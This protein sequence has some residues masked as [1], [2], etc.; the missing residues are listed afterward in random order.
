MTIELREDEVIAAIEN[1]L[2]LRFGF[3]PKVSH[4]RMDNR[5][6]NASVVIEDPK[7]KAD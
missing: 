4:V 3:R 1:F 2:D 5:T 6:H 7:R